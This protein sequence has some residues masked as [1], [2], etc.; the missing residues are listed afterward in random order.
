MRAGALKGFRISDFE[1][2]ACLGEEA[3]VAREVELKYALEDEAAFERLLAVLG[4][5]AAVRR[6]VNHY[7]TGDDSGLLAR[8]EAVLRLREEDG[9]WFLAFKH[10]LVREGSLYRC[11]EHESALPAA[12]AAALLSGAADPRSL[13]HP[14]SAAARARLGPGSLGPAG[15]SRTVRTLFRLDTGE[16]LEADRCLFPGGRTDFEIELETDDPA[17]GA[18]RISALAARAGMVLAAQERSKIRRFL[19]A[20]AAENP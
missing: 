12:V 18:A 7:F 13:D 2:G 15:S 17:R 1:P 20:A 5:P 16:I 14:A 9:S 10:G 6:Q 8:G 19:D 11:E 3:D 4:E